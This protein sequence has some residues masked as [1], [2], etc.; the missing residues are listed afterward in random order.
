MHMEMKVFKSN[1]RHKYLN[2]LNL[3]MNKTK[4]ACIRPHFKS[5]PK[6]AQTALSECEKLHIQPT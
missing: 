6:R 1:V 5:L 4:T 2:P 3:Y